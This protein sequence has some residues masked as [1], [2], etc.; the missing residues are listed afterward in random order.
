MVER[1]LEFRP[2]VDAALGQLGVIGLDLPA[3]AI[4]GVRG[5]LRGPL[6]RHRRRPTSRACRRGR[7]LS[8]IPFQTPPA[9]APTP[10]CCCCRGRMRAVSSPCYRSHTPPSRLDADLSFE[11]PPAT[12]RRLGLYDGRSWIVLTEANRFVC[13]VPICECP[14]T[15]ILRAYSTDCCPNTCLRGFVADSWLP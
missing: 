2:S 6:V 8:T 14:T 4:K 7:L 3:D 11:I 12:K 10:S 15:V 1:P 5:K 13:P 9:V